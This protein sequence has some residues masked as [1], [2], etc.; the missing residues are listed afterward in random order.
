MGQRTFEYLRSQVLA[1]IVAGKLKNGDVNAM[2]QVLWAGIHGVV[3]LLNNHLD[4]PLSK[5]INDRRAD[6]NFD[7]RLKRIKFFAF[8]LNAVK[9]YNFVT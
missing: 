1:C 6:R 4:F 8:S 3:S 7:Q 9:F 5:K 2:S